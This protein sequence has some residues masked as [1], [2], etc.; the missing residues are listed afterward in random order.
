M[1]R[2]SKMAFGLCMLTSGIIGSGLVVMLEHLYKLD[3]MQND[4]NRGLNVNDELLSTKCTFLS[5]RISWLD[6][7]ISALENK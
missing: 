3:D 7:R 1:D 6:K 4:I 2:G 5:D